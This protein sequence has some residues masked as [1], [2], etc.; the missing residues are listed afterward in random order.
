MTELDFASL[1]VVALAAF[2]V[3]LLLAVLPGPKI[4]SVVGEVVAG[5]ALGASGLGLIDPHA[6]HLEFLFL[7]GLAFLLF[8]AGL[9]FDPSLLRGT[10]SHGVRHALGSPFGRALL[11][12]AIRLAVA[13]AITVP[14]WLAGLLPGPVLVAFLL[15]STSLGIVLSVLTEHELLRERYGQRLFLSAAVADFATVLLLTIF[16]SADARSPGVRVALIAL[17]IALGL[18]LFW[19]LRAASSRGRLAALVERLSGAPAELRIRASFALLLAFVALA[20]EFGLEVILGAFVAGAI[21]SALSVGRAHPVYQ[22]KVDAIGYGFFVPVF[23]ILTGA[24]LDVPA[25]LDAGETLA[26]VPVL[27][28]AVF[29]VKGVPALLYRDEFA[30]RDCAAAGALQSAQMTLTVAGVEIGQ[31]LG[32]I[33]EALGAAL[34][35]VAL[36]SVLIAPIAFAALH[37]DTSLQARAKPERASS[38]RSA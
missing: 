14:L 25:L 18:A 11:G 8:L 27:L 10:L 2:A 4:P 23:F 36:L 38:T 20:A 12:M 17:L 24:R 34:I 37:G 15:S 32:L 29:L 1:V 28:V 16:F 7:F 5:V 3:P 9:E 13:F 21:V 19:G 6:G 30:W 35:C 31:R 22:V 26:L 33:D